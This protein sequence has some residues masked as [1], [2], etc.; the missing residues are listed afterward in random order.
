MADNAERGDP[1][2]VIKELLERIDFDSWL[3]DESSSPASLQRARDNVDEMLNWFERLLQGATPE[4]QGIIES[5][6]GQDESTDSKS[7]FASLVAHISL[8]D[9]LSRQQEKSE[10]SGDENAHSGDVHLMTMHAAKG[11]EF[12]H[13]YIPGMEEGILPHHSAEED[14][15]IE[16]ERRLAY[17]G[18]TRAKHRLTFTV[19]KARSRFGDTAG[20]TPSRFL[21][22]I[23]GDDLDQLGNTPDAESQEQN[24]NT[25]RDTLD[26]LRALL[27]DASA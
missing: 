21:D 8:M 13:V 19:A 20:T 14:P 22:E 16:E 26:S 2:A 12:S 25:G 9:M 7:D 4:T 6:P 27:G 18:M 23:P 11:L 17:V 3:A 5:T 1:L 10:L 15:Q 24:L